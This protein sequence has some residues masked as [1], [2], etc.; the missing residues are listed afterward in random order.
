MQGEQG[1][2]SPGATARF[3]RRLADLKRNGCNVLLVGTDGLDAACERLL[4]ESSAGPRYRVF[5][6]TD[7]SPATARE[8]LAS[9]RSDP[10]SDAAAVVNWNADVRG[11]TET[12]SGDDVRVRETSV[13]GPDFDAFRE[14]TVDGRDLDALRDGVG[15]AVAAFEREA[16][17][18]S[19][20]ELRLCVDSLTPVV[21]DHDDRAV[22]RLLVALTE[23]V[24]AV[25]GMGHFHLPTAFSH[26]TVERLKPLFDA[27]IEVRRSDAGFE[28]R[29][30]MSDPDDE[31]NADL[32]TEWLP[33]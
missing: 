29:W 4:G 11:A 30:H 14:T 18:L 17:G 22:E 26:G 19:P 23:T 8:G 1:R 3:R 5:V 10:S 20:A 16:G 27:T 6:T 33:L 13:D 24:A 9:V 25:D 31:T 12:G 15:D 2:G 32:E 7:A 28:Q 21:A